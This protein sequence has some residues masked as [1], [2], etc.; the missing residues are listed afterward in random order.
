MHK[1]IVIIYLCSKDT[2]T[3]ANDTHLKFF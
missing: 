1:T 2:T 3:I